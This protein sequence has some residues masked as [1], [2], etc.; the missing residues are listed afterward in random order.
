MCLVF[1]IVHWGY[2]SL[3]M[4]RLHSRN[5]MFAHHLNK[6]LWQFPDLEYD[7][8]Q[9]ICLVC[10]KS[11]LCW[12]RVL[13]KR[14]INS[15]T[16]K[17]KKSGQIPHDKFLFDL[18][19]MMSACNIPFNTIEKNTFCHFWK[20][21]NPKWKLPSRTTLRNYL[22]S[23]REK[24]EDTIK[25]ELNDKKLWLTVDKIKDSKKNVIANVIVRT[26]NPRGPSPPYLIASKRLQQRTGESII[27]LV[28]TTLQKFQL[29]T[30]QVLMFVTDGDSSMLLAGHCFKKVC[31][32]LIHITCVFHAL[33]I[34]IET[35]RHCYPD[36]NILIAHTKAVFLNSPKHIRKFHQQYPGIPEPPQLA[37]AR[38]GAWLEAAFYYFQY[39]QK[40]KSLVLQFG[41]EDSTSIKESQMKFQDAQVE[42]DL[43]IIHNNYIAIADAIHKLQNTSLS[44]VESLQI[45]DDVQTV[46]QTLKD[47]RSICVREKF[48]SVLS[49]NADFAR[50]RQVYSNSAA[51]DPLSNFK[52]YFKYAN[53]TS[54]DA[55]R[56]FSLY[57]KI[58]SPQRTSL[59]ETT[60]ETYAMLQM[61]SPTRPDF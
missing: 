38:W 50:L 54:L 45:V 18:I 40:I 28:L 10:N 36:V 24:I 51:G 30:N 46:L 22:P 23:V 42:A 41:A 4:S 16:H 26:L 39:F 19:F 31:P 11:L 47:K 21:Y 17:H 6:F 2:L 32:N 52:D 61:F 35:I 44:L 9:V 60:V 20:K 15:E 55:E 1:C 33:H 49:K 59:K 7:G 48:N 43:Q 34:V 8:A 53:I 56:S 25:F 12:N 5:R 29:S 27:R 57:N 14:H 13:C 58:F 3:N 37:L